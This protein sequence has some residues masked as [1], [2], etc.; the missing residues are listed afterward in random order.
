MKKYISIIVFACTMGLLWSCEKEIN[1]VNEVS[2]TEG[3]AFIKIV[4][5]AP[6]FRQVFKGADSFNIYVNGVKINGGQLTYNS[7]FPVIANVYAAVPAG[8]QSVRISVNGKL[9]PDSITLATIN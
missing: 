3:L 7:I 6:N 8:P 4:N 9:T 1:L 5:A 2:T